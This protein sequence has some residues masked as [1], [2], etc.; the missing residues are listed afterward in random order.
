MTLEWGGV[1]WGW[2]WARRHLWLGCKQL[3]CGVNTVTS[4]LPMELE[5]SWSKIVK[6]Q[7][8]LIFVVLWSCVLDI[9]SNVCI[10]RIRE[11]KKNR[12]KLSLCLW[13]SMFLNVLVKTQ[14]AA[15]IRK[16]LYVQPESQTV[17]PVCQPTAER[18]CT[19]TK[20]TSVKPGTMTEG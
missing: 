20:N 3:L 4:L 2:G 11:E 5:P 8:R 13:S 19:P 9:S 14:C 7:T 16:V 18:P 6:H 17:S 1:G 10:W 15:T 12:L